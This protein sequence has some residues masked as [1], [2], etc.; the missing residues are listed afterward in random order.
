MGDRLMP[1]EREMA[2]ESVEAPRCDH[3]EGPQ[4][5]APRVAASQ[6]WPGAGDQPRAG[7]WAPSEASA[8]LTPQGGQGGSHLS[9][10]SRSF[11]PSTQVFS[12][13]GGPAFSLTSLSSGTP[14]TLLSRWEL[15]G[16]GWHP[17]STPATLSLLQEHPGG[18]WP[19]CTESLLPARHPLRLAHTWEC[20]AEDTPTGDPYPMEEGSQW[21][22][23]PLFQL[24]RTILSEP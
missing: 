15:K 11:P 24:Q 20:W 6:N 2:G 18:S 8:V 13:W 14:S 23:T 16:S 17:P 12:L 4:E 5:M 19:L 21:V 9:E 1:S 22:N 3:R 7:Q 10:A